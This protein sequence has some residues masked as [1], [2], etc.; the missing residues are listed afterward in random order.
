MRNTTSA[1]KMKVIRAI[2]KS[3][4]PNDCFETATTYVA[5]FDKPGIAKP[6]SGIMK[7]AT[8]ALTKAPRY[9]PKTKAT[10]KPRTLY[11]VQE[12]YELIPHAFGRCRWWSFFNSF[13]NFL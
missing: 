8:S 2:K 6:K 10:A 12:V 4:I 3:P 7:S 13:S 1:T 5:K 9:K 11:D